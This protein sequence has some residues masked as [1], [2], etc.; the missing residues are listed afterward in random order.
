[1]KLTILNHHHRKAPV[2]RAY[3]P[4]RGHK[5]K[6]GAPLLLPLMVRATGQQ[7]R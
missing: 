6:T 2:E 7:C 4:A 5:R 3:D 1:M